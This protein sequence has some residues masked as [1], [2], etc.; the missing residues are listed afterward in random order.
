M[1]LQPARDG[2]VMLSIH[3]LTTSALPG[4]Q[5]HQLLFFAAQALPEVDNARYDGRG[6]RSS[7]AVRHAAKVPAKASS[8]AA[9]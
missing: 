5:M 3:E 8:V 2:R 9:P 4:K 7:C 1:G 6:R